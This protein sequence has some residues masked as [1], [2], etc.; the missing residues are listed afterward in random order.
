VRQIF[1]AAQQAGLGLRLHAEQFTHQGATQLAAAMGAA[2]VDHLEAI[3]PAGIDALAHSSTTA[4]ILPG[5]ALAC[6]CPWPPVRD[7]FEAH[8]PVALGTD[9]NPG[10]SMTSSLP[11]MMSIACMQM[12]MTCEEAWRAVTIEAARSLGCSHIGHLAPG[13][14]ADLVIF[15][16]PDYR[17]IPYHFGDNH[18]QTVIKNGNVVVGPP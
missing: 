12:K 1:S 3:S 15:H 2:S 11:L 6:R 17:Y 5:A 16:A 14:Q 18:V 8:V 7:L 9:L 13:A 4:I 10:S